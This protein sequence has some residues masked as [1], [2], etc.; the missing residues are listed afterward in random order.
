MA[1]SLVKPKSRHDQGDYLVFR[2]EAMAASADELTPVLPW[3]T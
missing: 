3:L 2:A 1:Q